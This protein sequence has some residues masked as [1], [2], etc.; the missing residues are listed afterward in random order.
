MSV[1]FVYLDSSSIVKRYVGERGSEVADTVYE[2]AEA[3]TLRCAFSI[4]NVGEVFGVF[5]KYASRGLLSKDML[6]TALLDFL[7]E[8]IK[9]AR[10]G[11]LEILPMTANSLIESWLLIL[12]YHIC[13][14][15]ALQISTSKEAGCDLLLSADEG[16]VQVARN[17][18][19]KAMNL[20]AEPE[21]ALGELEGRK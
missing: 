1:E 4:W 8:S 13:G 3:G 12:K 20:G 5:D 10:L 17:E 18:G 19:I 9:M 14:A 16:L 2:R 6:K 21:K 11:S 15:D 7:A